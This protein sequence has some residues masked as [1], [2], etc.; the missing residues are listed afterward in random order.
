MILVNIA[1]M[2]KRNLPKSANEWGLATLIAV[3]SAVCLKP[4]RQESERRLASKTGYVALRLPSLPYR[5]ST[6]E[7]RAALGLI[8]STTPTV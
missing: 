5:G 2:T 7:K 3:L 8:N 4:E 1:L 6:P